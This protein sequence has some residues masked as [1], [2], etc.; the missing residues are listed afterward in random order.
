ML[1]SNLSVD[2]IKTAFSNTGKV[3]EKD[4]TP[5]FLQELID[6]AISKLAEEDVNPEA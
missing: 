4:L 5:E 6:S 2:V 3:G 1:K